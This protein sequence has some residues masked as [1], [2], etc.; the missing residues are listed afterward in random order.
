MSSDLLN[1]LRK[2]KR[3]QA[4]A[5]A[6]RRKRT[7]RFGWKKAGLALLF[8]VCLVSLHLNGPRPPPVPRVHRAHVAVVEKDVPGR[9][10]VD[11]NPDPWDDGVLGN[12][13]CKES[14]GKKEGRNPL[15]KSLLELDGDIAIPAPQSTGLL[16]VGLTLFGVAS[17]RRR[18]CVDVKGVRS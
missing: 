4:L 9:A 13:N 6:Q 3:R 5:A 7:R 18:K 8:G 15:F 17:W 12:E 14:C 10:L 2:R 11:P 16:L 1:P